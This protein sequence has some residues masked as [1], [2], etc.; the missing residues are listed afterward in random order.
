MTNIDA[1]TS[2]EWEAYRQEKIDAH[3]AKGLE[4]LPDPTCASC[5][6]D[7]DYVCFDCELT[8]LDTGE[9]NATT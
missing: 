3:Y 9:K 4:L 7:N 5:D 2:D 8:Q 1:M 6:V